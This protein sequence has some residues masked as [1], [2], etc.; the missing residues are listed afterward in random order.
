MVL[1]A[2]VPD[3]PSGL[4]VQVPVAGKPVKATLPVAREQDGCVIVPIDGAEGVTGWI[5]ITTLFDAA[6]VHPAALVT[7]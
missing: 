4:M 5:L 3:I 6:E 7:V 1:P 2:P